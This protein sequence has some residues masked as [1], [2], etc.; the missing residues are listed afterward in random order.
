[1]KEKVHVMNNNYDI[2]KKPIN[3]DNPVKSLLHFKNL[4]KI[5]S[6]EDLL[7]QLVERIH[8]KFNP[9]AYFL[10]PLRNRVLHTTEVFS[11]FLQR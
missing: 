8:I 1:M 9:P 4:L 5:L 3:F 11:W 7:T 10:I 6:P 2:L